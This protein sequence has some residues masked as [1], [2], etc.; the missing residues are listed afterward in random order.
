MIKLTLSS[1][2]DFGSPAVNIVNVGSRGVD[3]VEMKKHADAHGIF[4]RELADL[5]PIPGHTLLHVLAVGDEETYGDNRNCDAFSGHDNKTAHVRFKTQGHVFK[6]HKNWDASLKTGEVIGTAHNPEMARIELLIALENAKYAEELAGFERGGD[7]PVSMGSM[8]KFDVCSRCQ[9]KAPTSKDHCEHIRMKLGE[10]GEDG[11]KNY[12][13]NPDPGYFDLSTVF[14]NADRIGFTLRKVAAGNDVIGGHELAEDF[15]LVLNTKKAMLIRLAEM[16]K[17]FKGVG[18]LT[19]PRGL[20]DDAIHSMRQKVAMFGT[21]ATIGDLHRRGCLLSIEDFA[22]AIVGMDKTAGVYEDASFSDILRDNDSF[23][24]LD[25]TSVELHYSP[26]IDSE[27]E[28]ST[29]MKTASVSHRT[30]QFQLPKIAQAVLP[31]VNKGLS[32]LY[33]HYKVAFAMY[34]S[35]NPTIIRSVVLTNAQ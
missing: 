33:Q 32:L 22:T 29:S 28:L 3:F 34:H 4:N 13:K 9:H 6:N 15:G 2:Y 35:D 7:I 25:G 5:K 8:Q 31:E 20:S 12:M 14:K 17:H 11:I 16:E 23:P 1:S 21:K 19:A 18:K 10:V 30:L 26:V 27:I 24:S